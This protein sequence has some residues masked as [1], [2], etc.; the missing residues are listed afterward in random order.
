MAKVQIVGG[1]RVTRTVK[2][3]KPASSRR[4]HKLPSTTGIDKKRVPDARGLTGLSIRQLMK[5]TP[6]YL[7]NNSTEVVIK[8]LKPAT[9]RGGFPAIRAVAI[10][11]GQ[12]GRK[13]SYKLHFIG[14]QAGIPIS[15]Q[16]HVLASCECDFFKYYSEYAL[17]HWGSA[18]IKFSNGEAPQMTNPGLQPLLCKHLAAL[19]KT[20]LAH[21]F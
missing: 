5:A 6:P 9:T 17:T 1:R 16:K 11:V 19:G 21:G 15:K 8:S 14:K 12:A 10:S 2:D 4:D 20:I 7:H 13:H 18:V 3:D